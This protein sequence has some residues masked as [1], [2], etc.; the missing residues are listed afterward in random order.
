MVSYTM[1]Q[2][3]YTELYH[4]INNF[5]VSFLIEKKKT[6]ATVSCLIG[7][8][9]SPPPK[10]PQEPLP[11]GVAFA[12]CRRR[13]RYG[14]PSPSAQASGIAG[15][16][17]GCCRS[18]H[19]QHKQDTWDI[20]G[21]TR[22]TPSAFLHVAEDGQIQ[23]KRGPPGKPTRSCYLARTKPPEQHKTKQK[24]DNLDATQL[25]QTNPRPTQKPCQP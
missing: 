21:T 18:E 5:T 20:P 3:A 19:K 2:Q 8:S 10:A 23:A 17:S 24:R 15:A 1:G 14:T 6:Y 4:L 25:M 12:A 7:Q 22:E 11:V 13:C 9:P 16:G